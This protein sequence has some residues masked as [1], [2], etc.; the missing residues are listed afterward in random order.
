MFGNK[1]I[2][3]EKFVFL[4]CSNSKIATKGWLKDA[5]KKCGTNYEGEK[6]SNCGATKEHK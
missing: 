1:N 2:I 6:M 3:K 4:K 5:C